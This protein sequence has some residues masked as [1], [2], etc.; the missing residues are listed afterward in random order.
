MLEWLEFG[1]YGYAGVY[2]SKTFLVT[3]LLP[4]VFFVF[5]IFAIATLCDQ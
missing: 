5:A 4:R 3:L 1:M 2:L